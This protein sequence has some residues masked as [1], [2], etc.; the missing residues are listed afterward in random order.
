MNLELFCSTTA[1]SKCKTVTFWS[2]ILS[3]H[4]KQHFIDWERGYLHIA[5][6]IYYSAKERNS[7]EQKKKS[8]SN[9][10]TQNNFLQL[11]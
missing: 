9:K 10:R 8:K 6:L 3:T 5:W 2:P 4:T 1:F 7:E 11:D